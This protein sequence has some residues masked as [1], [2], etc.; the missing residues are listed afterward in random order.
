MDREGEVPES[1]VPLLWMNHV[2]PMQVTWPLHRHKPEYIKR[3]GAEKLLLS[4][5]NYVLL[6][7]FTAKE[8]VRRL[9]AAP[10]VAQ[11][12]PIPQVGL[13]NHLN[14]VHR[15]AGSLT[16]EEA[17]G[18]AALYNSRLLDTYFRC[19]NGHTQVNA[20]ELRAMPLPAND[21]I[22]ELGERVQQLVNPIDHL[23]PL[24]ADMLSADLHWKFTPGQ[25]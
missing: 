8:E 21:F 9:S 1:H 17:W 11:S 3:E 4:N 5:R 25:R 23:D 19:L 14:Y 20:T 12:M 6:R 15:P 2:Q 7:R 24:I 16:D 22:V 13:E 10:Y 18:L